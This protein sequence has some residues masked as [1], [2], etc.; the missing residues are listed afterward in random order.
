MK[1]KL[2]NIISEIKAGYSF[3]GKIVSVKGSDTAIIQLKDF[4]Y[5]FQQINPPSVFL[6]KKTF[7]E[8][9]FLKRGD[10]LF[11][12][13]G[14]RNNAVTYKTENLAVAS[15]IFF[16][17]KADDN[18]V[19]PEY[20]SW[21]INSKKAQAYLNSIK[22][23]TSTVNINKDALLNMEVDLPDLEIQ[24]KIGDFYNLCRKEYEL[25]NRLMEKKNALN[26]Q[27]ILNLIEK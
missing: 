1:I 20:L 12:A 6:P 27:R 15:S 7:K 11:I 8:V 4:D 16:I 26:E 2:K 25:I 3:R 22:S 19:L 5:D 13:K 9:H 17:I 21:Y 10:V 14:V 24:Y 18:K 23:G